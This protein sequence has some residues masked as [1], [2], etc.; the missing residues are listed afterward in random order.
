MRKPRFHSWL[1]VKCPFEK[2]TKTKKK[3]LLGLYYRKEG[4]PKFM[5]QIPF[6]K[7]SFMFTKIVILFLS[8]GAEGLLCF[9]NWRFWATRH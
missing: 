8:A 4:E 5:P 2:K 3:M 1:R 7:W 9:S 6:K